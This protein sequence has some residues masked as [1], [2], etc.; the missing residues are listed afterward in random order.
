M[1]PQHLIFDEA[2]AVMLASARILLKRLHKRVTELA[3][4]GGD[5]PLVQPL[6]AGEL[7]HALTIANDAIFDVLNVAAHCTGD[8]IAKQYLHVTSFESREAS[9]A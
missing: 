3:L 4:Q 1:E 6:D 5:A 8:P 7:R 2:D 9:H